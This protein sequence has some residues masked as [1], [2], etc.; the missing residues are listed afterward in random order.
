MRDESV[1]EF[2]IRFIILAFTIHLLRGALR[3]LVVIERK[4]YERKKQL[5]VT[6]RRVESVPRSRDPFT[7]FRSC[8]FVSLTDLRKSA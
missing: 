4:I 2:K 8:R 1:Q 7:T 3:E 5:D 6:G